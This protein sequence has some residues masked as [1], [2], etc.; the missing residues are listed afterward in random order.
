MRLGFHIHIL[1]I[2]ILSTGAVYSQ[3]IEQFYD[4]HFKTVTQGYGG[5]LWVSESHNTSFALDSTQLIEGKYPLKIFP[6]PTTQYAFYEGMPSEELGKKMHYTLTQTILLPPYNDGSICNISLNC[7]NPATPLKL[8]IKGLDVDERPAHIDSVTIQNDSWASSTIS[9]LMSEIEALEITIEYCGEKKWD[10]AWWLSDISIDIDNINIGQRLVMPIV[11][12]N[13]IE[14]KTIKK[15]SVIPLSFSDSSTLLNIKDWKNKKI[16]ALGESTHGSQKIKEA[17]YQFLKHLVLNE[18]CKAI[19]LERPIDM[20]MTWDLYTQGIISEN[21]EEDLKQQ[22]QCAFD[23]SQSLFEFIKWIRIYNEKAENK[24][25]IF[26]IDNVFHYESGAFIASYFIALLQEKDIKEYLQKVKNKEY[27]GIAMLIKKDPV[28]TVLDDKAIDYLLF[29]LEQYADA[30]S[31]S[32]GEYYIQRDYN[33]WKRAKT[34]MRI[35]SSDSDKMAVYAHTNHID[36]VSY[37][38]GS[39]PSFGSYMNKDIKDQYFVVTFQVGKGTYTQDESHIHSQTIVDSLKNPLY[40]SL[41]YTCLAI[42]T[43]YFYC[44]TSKLVEPPYLLRI[45]PRASKNKNHFVFCSL[46]KRFDAFVFIKDSYP[47]N[48]ITKYPSYNIGT[49]IGQKRRKIESLLK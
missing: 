47:L 37:S 34:I 39:Q 35:Y 3:T 40:H 18:N 23:D 45:V 46:P 48:T 11:K 27:S 20:C 19:L 2:Y 30:Y 9:F 49:Y 25:H 41:E 6:S 7:M 15:E 38:R 36:K 44:L 28:L 26:G 8:R 42:G 5:G 22:L 33:M 21:Y 10:Q 4:L 24:V 12:E 16:I 13:E 17:C 43:P 31:Q 14:C 29:V 32:L 1:V